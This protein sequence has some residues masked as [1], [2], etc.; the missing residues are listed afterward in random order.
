MG[1]EA[2]CRVSV[3]GEAHEGTLQWESAVLL[4]RG[5]CRLKIPRAEMSSVASRDG[6]LIVNFTGREAS[7]QLGAAAAKW[8]DKILNPPSL[9][10]KLGIKSGQRVTVIGGFEEAFLTSL[11]ERGAVVSLKPAAGSDLVLLAAPGPKDLG[12]IA[13]AAGSLT[14]AGGL[15]IVYPKGQKAITEMGVLEA[16]RAAGLTDVKVVSFSETHTGLKFVVPRKSR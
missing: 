5:G 2:K 9:L 8:V 1:L 7:F 15:W 14:S 12:K 3:D 4:F 6:G 10:D 16:G 13:R 11:Q